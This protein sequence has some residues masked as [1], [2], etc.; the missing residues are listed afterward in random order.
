[1]KRG[2]SIITVVICLGLWGRSL[3]QRTDIYA[4]TNARIVPITSPPIER[5][6]IVI[7]DGKIAAVGRTVAIPAGARVINAQGMWVYPGMIDSSTTVGLTEIGQV[8][9]TVDVTELGDINPQLKAI[10]AVNPES[11]IIPVTRA[12]GITTVLT[13]PRGGVLAGQAALINLAGWTWEEML[14]KAP[15]GVIFNF[16]SLAAGRSFDPAT[17]QV[18][19]RSFEE[20]RRQRDERLNRVKR[21][22]EDARAYAAAKAAPVTQAGT[23]GDRALKSDPVLESLIPVVTGE[24]PLLVSADDARDIRA[25]IEFTSQQKVKMILLGGAE[26]PKVAALLKEKNI[27]VILGPVLSLPRNEDDPYDSAYTRAKELFDA[28]VTFAFSTNDASNA[29]NLPY[30]AAM[31]VAFGLPREEALKALTISPAKIFGVADRLGSIEVG[32]IANLV[33][34]DGDPLEIRSNVRHLL[35][36]GKEIPLTTK[37]TQLYE[38]YRNRP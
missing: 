38:K 10:V 23:N 22:F 8:A 6:T 33:V 28:G 27:P 25:A 7:R 26:A 29:R 14:V 5:G 9:A 35:I 32:K 30:H 34:W 4:I 13:A 16:P 2:L 31:A 24:L 20:V 17:F 37:H 3:A 11:E 19:E 15:V 1:M 12:N 18:R 21:L 36:N